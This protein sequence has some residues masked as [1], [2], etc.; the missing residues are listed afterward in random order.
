MG[1]RYGSLRRL[2]AALVAVVVTLGLVEL[3]LRLI[4]PP[5]ASQVLRGLHRA[6]PDKPWLYELVPGER[7]RDPV[8][9][10]EYTINQAG[11]RDA[12]RER[13]KPAGTFRI[14][15]IGDS[16]TFGYGV[17]FEATFG[18]LLEERLRTVASGRRWEVLNFGVSGFNPYT[19]AALLRDVA[20]GY[21][22]DLVL[23]QFCVNDLN[24]PTQHFDTSTM[25]A[26]GDVPAAAFP[27]PAH[28]QSAR[29]RPASGTFAAVCE[30]SRLCSAVAQVLE[31]A[32][33]AEEMVAALKP[34]DDPSDAEIAWLEALYDGMARDAAAHG[35]R[36]AVVVF[37]FQ[38][39]VEQGIADVLQQKLRAMGARA[40]IPVVDLL[41]SF[42]RA[43]AQPGERLFQDMWHPAARGH[44]V[45]AEE[46]F[47]AL[48]GA[49][50]LPVDD[51]QCVATQSRRDRSLISSRRAA[52][53]SRRALRLRFAEAYATAGFFF[54]SVRTRW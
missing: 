7:R 49:Q 2:A 26:L 10:V 30:A 11:F 51:P 16:L 33:P 44:R 19:E 14:A 34:H 46:L 28:R 13:A 53:T 36:L 35:E 6:A 1:L 5:S 18:R 50:L 43:A 21:A 3:V 48:V 47:C 42:R 23:V 4:V 38:A 12:E 54:A 24:D 20:L 9:G 27:D 17:E 15:V 45:A 39:Q 40:G 8:L 22:P 41:P 52:Q 32:R 29:K 25:H 37:P 31:P